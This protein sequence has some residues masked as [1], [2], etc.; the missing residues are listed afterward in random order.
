MNRTFELNGQASLRVSIEGGLV[1]V[2]TIDGTAAH[3]DVMRQNG[4]EPGDDLFVGVRDTAEGPEVAVEL[5]RGSFLSQFTGGRDLRVRVQVPHGTRPRLTTASAD[6]SARGSY[7]RGKVKSASG[8][9]S[10][11]RVDGDLEIQTASGD[12]NVQSVA[13]NLNARSASGNIRVGRCTGDVEARTASGDI[14]L[15]ELQGSRVETQTASGDVNIAEVSRGSVSMRSASGDF[16]IGVKRG[17]QVWMDTRSL[18]GETSSEL[19]VSDHLEPAN[20]DLIEIRATTVSGDIR[21]RRSG[22]VPA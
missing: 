12:L 3:V 2:S 20:G 17:S 13:G 8:D 21:I 10:V 19:E 5:S 16:E 11:E 22:A 6:I 14:E 1:E 4:E 9:T 7:G 15:R 18:S